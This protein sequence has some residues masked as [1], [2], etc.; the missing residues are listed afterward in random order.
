VSARRI[1]VTG[2]GLRTSNADSPDAYAD[3]LSAGRSGVREITQFDTGWPFRLGGEVTLAPEEEEPGLDRVS[4]LAVAAARQAVE[5]GG[6]ED[7]DLEDARAGLCLGT[8]RG[9]ALSLERLLRTEAPDERQA[10]FAEVPFSSIARNVARRLGLTGP[11][12]TVTMACV[13]S[14][15]AIGRAWDAVRH[16]QADVMIAGGADSLTRLSFSGFS[17]LRAMTRSSCRPFD[18]RRDGMI[19]GEGAG[20]L[21]LEDLDHARRRGARVYAEICGWGTAGDAHHATS[22]HPQGRGLANAIRAALRQA[23]MPADAIDHANLHGT[24]TQANDPAECQ[25]VRQVFGAAAATLPVNS[26]KPMIGHTL[27]AAGVLELAGSLLGM[28]GGFVPP[29]LNYGEPDPSCALNVVGGEP[30]EM[31]IDALLSTKSAFGGANVAIVAR[32]M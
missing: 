7:G 32:R 13:S 19:L 31:P 27:G 20:F 10:L 14:S 8:S 29:T 30:L 28:R 2:M 16:G 1:V 15:L 24:G 18:R 21:V 9:P 5:D 6:L 22:P 23:Q 3:A 12:S 25:A 11:I 26:L 17:V 4:Q